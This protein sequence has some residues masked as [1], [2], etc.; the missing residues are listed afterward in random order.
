MVVLLDDQIPPSRKVVKGIKQ[1][2]DNDPTRGY[3][4]IMYTAEMANH[5]GQEDLDN[6]IRAAV[7][8]QDGGYKAA[9]LRVYIDD[10]WLYQI[11]AE[12]ERR[13]FRDIR[14]PSIILKGDVYFSWRSPD[15]DEEE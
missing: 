11:E 9:Y 14:V 5:D 8:E 6:R 3:Q 1:I 12:L 7:R 15:E 2:L 10:P 13:G 4:E